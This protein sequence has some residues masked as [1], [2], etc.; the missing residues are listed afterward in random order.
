M[1]V[2]RLVLLSLMWAV[3]GAAAGALCWGAFGATVY[4]LMN[5]ASLSDVVRFWPARFRG[6]LYFGGFI[7]LIVIP[8][9]TSVFAC[10][11]SASHRRPAL[12]ASTSRVAR[13]SLALALPLVAAVFAGYLWPA[14]ALGPFWR[15]AIVL[16]PF[17]MASVWAGVFLPRVF[18][19]PLRPSHSGAA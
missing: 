11:L 5:G 1:P 12:E 15:E 4:P 16:T 7:A 8:F 2:R 17:A 9:Y 19:R 10:W 13:S 6:A 14:G 18:V 3:C